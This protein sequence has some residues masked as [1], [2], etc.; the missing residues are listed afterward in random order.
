[1]AARKASVFSR[2]SKRSNADGSLLLVKD[3]VAS[4]NR[5]SASSPELGSG[6]V[7]Q[8]ASRL[9]RRNWSTQ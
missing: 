2:A 6:S 9:L 8:R 5:L 4:S 3:S 1:M 7:N